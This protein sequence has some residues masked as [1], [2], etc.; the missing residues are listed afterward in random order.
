MGNSSSGIIEAPLLNSKVLNIGN[1]QKGRFRFGSVY[2]VN[3]DRKSISKA[4]KEIFSDK[5]SDEFDLCK[6]KKLYK[7]NSPSNQIINLL[8]KTTLN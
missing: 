3:G 6:F 8:N 7:N 4:L 2:D 1:R 5:D